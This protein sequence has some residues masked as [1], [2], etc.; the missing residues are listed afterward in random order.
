[1]AGHDVVKGCW[2]KPHNSYSML[3]ISLISI[4]LGCWNTDGMEAYRGLKCLHV[5]GNGMFGS[6]TELNVGVCRRMKSLAFSWDG[7]LGC[8]KDWLDQRSHGMECWTCH[9]MECFVCV[10]KHHRMKCR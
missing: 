2:K 1:M 10:G 9:I 4:S 8:V 6:V 7:I 3:L 5:S